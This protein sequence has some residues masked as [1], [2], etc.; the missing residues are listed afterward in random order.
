MTAA[1]DAGEWSA[2]VAVVRE[3]LA[4]LPAVLEAG[5]VEDGLRSCVV[6]RAFISSLPIVTREDVG[7]RADLLDL[8][9]DTIVELNARRSS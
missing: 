7:I 1:I 4:R 5:A 8:V 6:L 3:R 9:D 2:G